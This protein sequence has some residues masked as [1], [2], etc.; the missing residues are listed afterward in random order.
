M[1]YPFDFLRQSSGRVA[2]GSPTPLGHGEKRR[3]KHCGLGRF[4]R[5][6]LIFMPDFHPIQETIHIPDSSNRIRH[7]NRPIY[8]QKSQSNLSFARHKT[9]P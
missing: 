6:L 9:P 8:K 4:Q 5:G 2:Q 7:Q 1:E 3:P